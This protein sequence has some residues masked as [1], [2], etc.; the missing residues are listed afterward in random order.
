[1]NLEQ[2]SPY[3]DRFGFLQDRPGNETGNGIMYS[4]YLIMWGLENDYDF[5]QLKSSLERCF[6]PGGGMNRAPEGYYTTYAGALNQADDYL[7]LG[8]IDCLL[9][10]DYSKRLLDISRKNWGII[11]NVEPGKFKW[12]AWIFR[13]PQV[14]THLQFAAGERPDPLGTL[15]WG[16]RLLFTRFSHRDSRIKAWL[17]VEVANRK[18]KNSIILLICYI[19]LQLFKKKYQGVGH[20]EYFPTNHPAR[21]YFWD[22]LP[23]LGG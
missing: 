16:L 8:L 23:K 4:V 18:T 17:M 15:F 2:W 7:S 9:H 5:S 1:V 13:M 6:V 3:I 12:K 14:R 10:T 19:W 22:Y 11:N 21:K 20:A